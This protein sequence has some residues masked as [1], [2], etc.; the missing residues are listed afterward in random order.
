MLQCFIPGLKGEG[1]TRSPAYNAIRTHVTLQWQCRVSCN[2]VAARRIWTC[3]MVQA[4][5]CR[6]SPDT[7]GGR[8]TV[9]ALQC[10]GQ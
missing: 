10:Q 8:D 4:I 9:H 2:T 1:L 3:Q 6:G 5:F 7:A